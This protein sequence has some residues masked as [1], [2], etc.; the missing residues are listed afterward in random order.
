[1]A[2]TL[3]K[4]LVDAGAHTSVPIEDPAKPAATPS[5]GAASS[6]NSEKKS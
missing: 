6:K 3:K 5:G 4:Q 1:L 2:A